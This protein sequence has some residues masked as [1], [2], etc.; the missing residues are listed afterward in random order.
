MFSCIGTEG[1]KRSLFK[2]GWFQCF[3][4]K[5]LKVP[6][7]PCLEMGRSEEHTS[8]LQSH[9]DLVCRLLLEKKK[10]IPLLQPLVPYPTSTP[11]VLRLSFSLLSPSFFLLPSFFL[12]FSPSPL[13]LLLI[14]SL[15]RKP[16]HSSHRR[17]RGSSFGGKINADYFS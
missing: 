8:E 4:F 5:E 1:S 3:S 2:T 6:K 7:V 16:L 15:L 12:P 11:H 13:S 17:S 9:S 10:N 14:S